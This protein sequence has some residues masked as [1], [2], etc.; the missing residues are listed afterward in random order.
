MPADFN[1]Y[2]NRQGIRGKKGEKGD[3]GF[4]PNISI[5]ENTQ[6][7]FT[8]VI[9]NE[10]ESFETPNLKEGL[11]PEDRG[12]SY[13]RKDMET[14]L[15]YYGD[16]DD[17]STTASGVIRIATQEEVNEGELANGAVVPETLAGRLEPITSTIETIS[18]QVTTNTS[19]IETLQDTVED[20][21]S[22][23]QNLEGDVANLQTDVT[24]LET[25]VTE[26]QADITELETSVS[27]L[28]NNVN[29]LSTQV[30]SNTESITTLESGK[31]NKLVAGDNITI[32]P[33]GDGTETI[34]STG[35]GGGA[36]DVTAAG[37]NVFTGS[38]TFQQPI[39]LQASSSGQMINFTD[40]YGT[41]LGMLKEGSSEGLQFMTMSTSDPFLLSTVNNNKSV[42]FLNQDSVHNG[43]GI[44]ITTTNTTDITIVAEVNQQ[45]VDEL[46]NEL[47]TLSGTVTSLGS[48]VN[49]LEGNIS[50]LEESVSTLENQMPS[51]ATTGTVGTVKPDG[52]TITITDDGTISAVGGGS[53][54]ENMVTTDTA[55]N[56]TGMKDFRNGLTIS[57]SGSNPF[58]ITNDI[59]GVDAGIASIN[60][61]ICRIG[62]QITSRHNSEVR[63]YF[64]GANYGTIQAGSSQLNLKPSSVVQ[65][66][67]RITTS[68]AGFVDSAGTYTPF[69]T[70]DAIGNLKY[71][72]LT[73]TAY[74]ALETKNPDTMYRVTD[75][76]GTTTAVYLGTFQLGGG[77]TVTPTAATATNSIISDN[78]AGFTSPTNSA[79]SGNSDI[80]TNIS[81]E[82]VDEQ[83]E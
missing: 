16:A 80:N 58:S 6:E 44:T 18:T 68:G 70:S 27:T 73:D 71:S 83:T 21:S 34:S 43:N 67:L 17:A 26:A 45:D 36:G 61:S 11:V 54:P 37:N 14:G 77:G 78:S 40:Q 76:D 74:A 25:S 10:F 28:Q 5:G 30:T 19:N 35:G 3:K 46:G 48:S 82:K 8:L 56:I 12:G 31:Q 33:N 49:T 52:T 75:A 65:A 20:H 62:A 23:I 60:T 47:N 53:T 41:F 79:A 57:D 81:I 39:T 66:G 9:Q 32:T 7:E 2:I 24:T 1:F 50:T 64:S 55:Q 42:Y 72:V 59:A 15:Q 22:R 51:I 4:S 69:A 63:L 29:T 38:N 13:V